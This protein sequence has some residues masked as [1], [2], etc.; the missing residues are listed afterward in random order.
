LAVSKVESSGGRAAGKGLRGG[1]WLEGMTRGAV[2]MALWTVGE[3]EMEE[4]GGYDGRVGEKGE[5]GHL[6]TAGGAEQRQD[7]VEPG[8]ALQELEGR[9][10]D[11]GAPIERRLGESVEQ[12]GLRARR[13]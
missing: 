1:A 4:D 11:L 2:G 13:G 9:E 3:V 8:E 5:D 10:E 6:A 7:L 12:P